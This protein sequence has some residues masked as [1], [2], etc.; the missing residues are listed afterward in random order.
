MGCSWSLLAN[1]APYFNLPAMYSPTYIRQAPKGKPKDKGLLNFSV[2]AF[3]QEM[4]T[5]LLNT[6]CLLNR[7]GH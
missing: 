2:F 1:I 4:S 3:F 7:G 6:D 5:C